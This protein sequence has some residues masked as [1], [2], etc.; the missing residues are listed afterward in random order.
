MRAALLPLAL[1]ALATWLLAGPFSQLLETTL[2]FHRLHGSSTWQVIVEVATTP[3]TAV[4][5]AAIS[6]G[7][8][9][10]WWRDRLALVAKRL[11]S[12]ARFAKDG[13]G[14]EK[15]NQFVVD[16]TKYVASAVRVTQT[17]QLNWNTA[18]ITGGLIVVLAVLAWGK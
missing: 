11:H 18:G 17:G 14:F 1:G 16:L 12:L 7:L 9:T 13:F 15:V 6:A 3:A 2:P 8:V 10:W 5:L 4:A